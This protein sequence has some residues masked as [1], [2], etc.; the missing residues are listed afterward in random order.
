MSIT[1]KIEEQVKYAINEVKTYP[2]G[3][4]FNIKDI[5]VVSRCIGATNYISFRLKLQSALVKI[6]SPIGNERYRKK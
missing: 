6:C 4:E 2:K 1:L 5:L 3:Y